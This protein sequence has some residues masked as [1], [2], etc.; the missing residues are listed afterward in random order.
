MRSAAGFIADI[1]RPLFVIVFCLSFIASVYLISKQHYHFM[2]GKIVTSSY[3][4]WEKKVDDRENLLINE[5]FKKEKAEIKSIIS[6]DI[7]ADLEKRD[8]IIAIKNKYS[9]ILLSTLDVDQTLQSLKSE[10]PKRYK[11]AKVSHSV[12]LGLI[13][14]FVI[15]FVWGVYPL[16]KHVVTLFENYFIERAAI[17]ENELLIKKN[18]QKR[19]E[20]LFQKFKI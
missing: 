19:K 20:I 14:S 18:E 7:L 2:S 4:N 13:F 12:F 1:I 9:L 16:F 5:I 17:R 6:Q 10:E 3:K 15:Y 11:K 8:K